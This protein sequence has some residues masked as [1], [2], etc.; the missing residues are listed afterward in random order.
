MKKFILISL[1]FI[2]QTALAEHLDLDQLLREVKKSQGVE[3]K[4][5]RA[6]EA[7]FLAEKVKQQ[8]L[9]QD[10]QSALSRQQQLSK[11]LKAKLEANEQQ[12]LELEGELKNRSGELGELFG[13]ARQAAGDLKADLTNSIISAQ[14]P[15]RLQ[16]LDEIA[17]SKALPTI[18]QLET[19]WFTLQQEMTESAKV[20]SFDSQIQTASGEPREAKVI[21]IGTFNALADGHYLRYLSETGK[22]SE[23][24]RQPED[25]Y[26]KL[27]ENLTNSKKGPVAV[28]I[29]PTRG[30]IL[31][32]LIQTPNT[33]ERIDQGGVI[34]YIIL[35][36]G[37]FGLV[38]ALARL[39]Y[40][41][42]V[43]RKMQ[44]QINSDKVATDNPLGR[45]I[46][47]GEK[48]SNE[49]TETL[50]LLLDEAITREVPALEKGVSM[51]KL[52]AAVAPLLGL[53]GTVTGMIATFQSISLFGTGDP[54]LMASG[55]SQ[56]LVTTMLGLCVAIPLL[57]L[58]SLVASRSRMLVQILD[59]QSAGI[60]SRRA[61]K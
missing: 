41:T 11:Q 56:A 24:A 17:N 61:G 23:L 53:L 54:K 15:G 59:E 49:D 28:G 22:L 13:V 57:F 25:K 8:Q 34:G 32:M 29:D 27:A 43:G 46:A 19:L 6:R 7:E 58:H 30:V 47:A 20:V 42:V 39:I 26:L 1:C 51:I 10:A 40:L 9:L 5:N 48:S 33:V 18:E 60:V 50:E 16:Q 37:A 12:L 35:L 31:S 38:Y 52:L 55:I 44:Q 3:A 4:I 36:L 45:V 21:R 2:V 14:F